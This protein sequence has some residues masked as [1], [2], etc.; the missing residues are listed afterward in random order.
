MLSAC[1]RGGYDQDSEIDTDL[2]QKIDGLNTRLIHA[3]SDNRQDSLLAM[4]G[5]DLKATADLKHGMNELTTFLS[6]IAT[7]WPYTV[8]HRFYAHYPDKN[9]SVVVK[10]GEEG[11]HDYAIRYRS[12][13]R[14]SF[15][16][17]GYFEDSGRSVALLTIWSSYN[18]TWKLSTARAGFVKA[19]NKD[20]VDW[21][22]HARQQ[23]AG[24]DLIDAANSMAICKNLLQPGG[25]H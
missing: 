20:A 22:Y 16:S 15:V 25:E 8:R 23:Y 10:T 6:G 12:P 1:K 17:V 21:Y 7:K 14:R 4:C 3:I 13:T 9:R 2:Q 18:G 24:N 11:D 19:F 5:D